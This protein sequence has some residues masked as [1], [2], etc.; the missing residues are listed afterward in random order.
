MSDRRCRLGYLVGD[1]RWLPVDPRECFKECFG[2]YAIG[3]NSLE[4]ELCGQRVRAELGH[5]EPSLL[6]S[7]AAVFAEPDWRKYAGAGRPWP[8]RLYSCACETT[9]MH[10]VS[11]ATPISDD[12]DYGL[13]RRRWRCAGHPPLVLPGQ[14]AGLELGTSPDWDALVA[15]HLGVAGVPPVHPFIDEHLGFP[16]TRLYIALDEEDRARDRLSQA[17]ASLALAPDPIVRSGVALFFAQSPMASGLDAVLEAWRGDPRLYD[18]QRPGWGSESHLRGVLLFALTFRIMRSAALG[19]ADPA[20]TALRWAATTSPGLQNH[21][22]SLPYADADWAAAHLEEL[23]AA[24][25]ADWENVLRAVPVARAEQLTPA[26]LGVLRADLTTREE[27]AEL[28][29]MEYHDRGDVVRAVLEA[30]PR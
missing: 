30:L 25:P 2:F 13:N 21:L 8:E 5:W 18:Q 16:L 3:C 6:E 17:V 24:A 15:A 26:C 27:L 29:E 1:D 28:L 14:L 9:V 23:I 11:E 12:L 22:Y 20:L 4:C 10:G 7:P 19:T